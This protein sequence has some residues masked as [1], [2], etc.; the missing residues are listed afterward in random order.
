MAWGIL[1]YLPIPSFR[2][3]ADAHPGMTTKILPHQLL[4]RALKTLDRDREHALREQPADDGG[5]FRI[6][7][8]PLRH[9]IEPHRVRIGARDTIEPDRACLLVDMLDRAARHHDLVR[10]HRGVTDEHYLVV[11][12]IFMQHVPGRRA[13]GKAAAV[14]L[15]DAFIE[16]V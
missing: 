5:G 9:R 16:A 11:V 7:P 6:V 10:A 4:H 3:R 13:V 15:P 2:V 12:R 8:M 14:L 1:S